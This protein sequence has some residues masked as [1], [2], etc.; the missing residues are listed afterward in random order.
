MKIIISTRQHILLFRYTSVE[1]LQKSLHYLSIL[2]FLPIIGSAQYEAM[3][4]GKVSNELLTMETYAAD[5]AAD[6]LVLGD[7][8]E[9]EFELGRDVPATVL[10]RHLRIKILK[11]AGM[12]FADMEFTY[13]S[14]E[15]YQHIEQIRGYVHL[16]DGSRKR[17]KNDHIFRTKLNDGQ[18]S[19]RV[20]FPNAEV[21]SVVECS[22]EWRTNSLFT[23]PEWYFQ[24]DI[25]V[26]WS[27]YKVEIPEW[28]Q[29]VAITQGPEFD[30]SRSEASARTY[31]VKRSLNT[32]TYS[33]PST[34]EG[35]STR[36]IELGMQDVPAMRPERFSTTRDDYRSR[37]RWQL[38]ATAAAEGKVKKILTTW[39]DAADE[40]LESEQFGQQFL[41]LNNYD[42]VLAA[43]RPILSGQ[44]RPLEKMKAI[45]SMVNKRV[46]WNGKYKL[47]AEDKLNA[48]FRRGKG[49]SSEL[50][51]IL[52]ALLREA[53]LNPTPIVLST[54]GHGKPVEVYPFMSQFNHVIVRLYVDGQIYYLDAGDPSRPVNLIRQQALNKR[55]LLLSNGNPKWIDIDPPFSTQHLIGQLYLDAEGNLQ[56]KIQQQA[57][58]YFN[59]KLGRT[60][61]GRDSSTGLLSQFSHGDYLEV[62]ATQIEVT[63]APGSDTLRINYNIAASGSAQRSGDYLYVQALP[64]FP[65][66]QNPFQLEQRN[67][68]V[69][70]PYP[71]EQRFTYRLHLPE[72]YAAKDLPQAKVLRLPDQA[73]IFQYSISEEEAGVLLVKC[74]LSIWE[75]HF[76]PEAYEALK[77][78]FAKAINESKYMLALKTSTQN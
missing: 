48:V 60:L 8:A 16:P 6:A 77:V 58:G 12:R 63:S 59:S 21:G 57:T 37:V 66:Q 47:A 78:F 31:S 26:R 71:Y 65:F 17:I 73:G 55:G 10:K 69:E 67:Y 15:A 74:A 13:R 40:L 1:D 7:C 54:R 3:R 32:G 62:D 30:L 61:V 38:Q 28:F 56:G 22:Y 33:R 49:N 51:L 72:G 18:S 36:I 9:V 64:S 39:S 27:L 53:G 41:E 46:S 52:L 5:P 75:P 34:N 19:V 50:N 20:S 25:P 14:A 44:R 24:H 68:P 4:M 42:E 43:A 23:L 29:Y 35:I 76:E 45:Y 11:Q 70:L 2:L